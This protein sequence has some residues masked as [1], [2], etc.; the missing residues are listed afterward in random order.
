M[1]SRLCNFLFV[2]A[3]DEKVKTSKFY[4]G[5]V[6]GALALVGATS[7][8]AGAIIYN[9]GSASTASVA[10]G[11]NDLGNL[12]TYGTGNIVINSG[13]TGLAYKFP[14]GYWRDSTSPGCYCEGWG[15]SA[16]GVSG[17]ADVSVGTA[18]LA[19]DSFTS[20]AVAGSGTFVTSAV[21]LTSLPGLQVSQAYSAADYSP[22]LFKDVVTIKNTTG[23]TLTDVRYVRVMDWDIPYT[24]FSEMVTIKGTA[25]T[26]LLERSHNNGF[27]TANPLAYDGEIY[28]YCGV[29]VDFTD[30]GSADHGAYFKFNFGTLADGES[31]NFTVFYGATGTEAAANTAIGAE[32]IE[33]YSYG[34]SDSGCGGCSYTAGTPA[35]YI[36]GFKGVG[37]EPQ[38]PEPASLILMG[39]GLMGLG[40]MKRRRAE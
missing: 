6:L 19:L 3:G 21:H 16:S 20:D 7:A 40:A 37:G 9:T 13:V 35:T 14:D 4:S 5:L 2:T 15:V 11:V 28:P 26:T 25:T 24:E 39:L 23:G 12:N 18:G 30:C 38:L 1:L 29:N 8:N 32:G 33:L 27:N 22:S 17:Y 36:F 34:Q 10:L 31:V